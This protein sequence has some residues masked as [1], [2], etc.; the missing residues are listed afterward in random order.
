[1]KSKRGRPKR[2]LTEGYC[3]PNPEC[4]Y[5]GIRDSGIHALV[6]DGDKLTGQGLVKQIKCQWCG[7]KFLVTR[8][9]AMYCSKL[10]A[11][12]VGGINR[13]LVEG[14]NISACVRFFGHC[15]VTIH[16]LIRVSGDHFQS[17]HELL[18]QGIHGVHIQMDG[19]TRS[20]VM[21][22]VTRG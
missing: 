10:S 11:E 2:S 1:M 12:R 8:D 20:R 15:R 7:S 14:L 22:C 18:L 9:T 13:G 6:A 4:E 21:I 3:C 16:R 19:A 17:L 5:R